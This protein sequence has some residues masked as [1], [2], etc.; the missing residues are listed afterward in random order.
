MESKFII[1]YLKLLKLFHPTDEIANAKIWQLK[2]D[3]SMHPSLTVWSI[4]FLNKMEKH[5]CRIFC[6][7][8]NPR[9]FGS[10]VDCSATAPGIWGQRYLV[11]IIVIIPLLV[12]N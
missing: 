9:N 1:V 5:F 2:L 8:L 11:F 4:I 7:D 10:L 6:L 3:M 12:L